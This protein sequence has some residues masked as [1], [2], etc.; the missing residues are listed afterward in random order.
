MKAFANLCVAA[1]VTLL[2][3]CGGGDQQ[4]PP[5]SLEAPQATRVEI[6]QTGLLLTANGATAQLTAKVFD[7]AGTELADPVTWASSRPDIVAVG[8]DGKVTA[9]AAAGSAQIVAKSGALTSQ[10]LLVAVS[11]PAPGVT[12]LSDMQIV[13]LPEDADPSAEPGRG[14]SYQVTLESGVELPAVGARLLGSG[15]KPLAGEV[16]AVDVTTRRITL[17]LVPMRELL[18]NLTINEVIDLGQVEPLIPAQILAMYDV[19]RVGDRFDFTPKPGASGAAPGRARPTA[20]SGTRALPPFDVCEDTL[21]ALGQDNA[22]L[23]VALSA[24]PAFSVSFPSTLEVVHSPANGLERLMLSSTPTF[25][26]SAGLK[27]TAAIDGK[28]ECKVTLLEFPVPVTGALHWIAG[29]IVPVGVGFELGGKVTLA[30]LELGM[31]YTKQNQLDMGWTCVNQNCEFGHDS[32]D[33]TSEF[34][35]RIDLPSVGDFRV[36][37]STGLFGFAELQMGIAP[38]LR[39]FAPGFLNRVLKAMSVQMAK[40]SIMGKSTLS[41]APRLTQVT[42]E[43][44]KSNYKL[45]VE[46]KVGLG[47]K[48]GDIAKALGMLSVSGVEAIASVDLA[49]SPTGTATADRKDFGA[50]DQL[51]FNASLS[52]VDQIVSGAYNV[53]RVLLV[54]QVPGG[55][56]VVG[57]INAT[58]GQRDFEFSFAPTA[59]GHTDEFFVFV[60][61]KALDFNLPESI[62]LFPFE[63]GKV[64]GV[65]TAVAPK[66]VGAVVYELQHNASASGSGG[67]SWPSS[68]ASTT[69]GLPM[70][71]FTPSGNSSQSTTLRIESTIDTRTDAATGTLTGAY[72]RVLL[73]QASG[74]GTLSRVGTIPPCPGVKWD[75]SAQATTVAV[76]ENGQ[77]GRI[78]VGTAG[79]F[80]IFGPQY[81]LRGTASTTQ[82]AESWSKTAACPENDI[83]NAK[84]ATLNAAFG[85]R[86]T[87]GGAGQLLPSLPD[88]PAVSGVSPTGGK[89][90][91]TH[92]FTYDLTLATSPSSWRNAFGSA[93]TMTITVNYDLQAVSDRPDPQ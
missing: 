55:T 81:R 8:T 23:P 53:G 38:S 43:I 93:G 71:Q 88:L 72:Q 36:E 22:P 86:T 61:T 54:R 45:A 11:A 33:L 18:P 17:R 29:G 30:T 74:M 78:G 13:G 82:I 64:H 69:T 77:A 68:G 47:Q 70:T 48:L 34:K 19:T 76:A 46:A 7:T 41:V 31:A 75:A 39:K 2:A 50:G 32:V 60:T 28:V 1:F 65:D 51:K 92:T 9:R 62:D 14:N 25:V 52:D 90:A 87:S 89:L 49:R 16:V 5:G 84:V 91:G 3:A 57:S 67:S 59:P 20:A 42:D 24:L 4:P 56:E 27:L 6:E 21:T 37:L 26:A 85:G 66:W 73:R 79:T 44:Y 83:W 63:I 80:D 12:L 40:A 35:P 10:P 58:D 15:A